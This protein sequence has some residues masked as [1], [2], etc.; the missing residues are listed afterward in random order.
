MTTPASWKWNKELGFSLSCPV[1]VFCKAGKAT[2]FLCSSK[3]S[4]ILREALSM[5][6][7]ICSTS[8]SC[9]EGKSPLPQLHRKTAAS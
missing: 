7:G 1:H 8:S 4:R 3:V 6:I 9:S 2:A 5:G